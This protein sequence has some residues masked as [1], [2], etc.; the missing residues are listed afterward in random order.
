MPG[1]HVYT[2]KVA[3]NMVRLLKNKLVITQFMSR[4]NERD[5]NEGPPIGDSLRVKLPHRGTIRDGFDYVGQAIDRRY[6]T[7]DCTEKFGIDVDWDTIEAA[8]QMER[9][10]ED[11]NE[12]ILDPMAAKLAQECDSRAARFIY[13]NS[14]NVTGALGTTPTTLAAYSAVRTRLLETAGLVGA[15]RKGV[16]VTPEMMGTLIANGNNVLAL[17]NPTDTVAKAFKEGYIGMYGGMQYYESMSLYRHTTG[18]WTTVATGVTTS[19][20][21]QSGTSIAVACTTG[22]TFKAG[23]VITFASVYAVNKMTLRSTNRLKQFK[24]M[25]DTTGASSTATLTISP[26]IVGPGSP[27]QNVD[28]LPGN[29]VVL[30]LMPGT[31]MSNAAAKEGL[32]GI[33]LTDEAFALVG[34]DLPMP[35]KTS[36]EYIGKYTDPETGITAAIIRSFD[37]DRRAW[38]TR[39]DCWV[40]FGVMNAEDSSILVASLN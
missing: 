22:D 29:G 16:I 3:A 27:Y 37:F 2:D 35:K 6:T 12:N 19:S 15:K 25:A 21:S 26:G 14:P 34:V 32:F 36:E 9:T 8:T 20:G 17:F 30:T 33:G 5:F 7:I 24:I 10:D 28:A 23:D 39:M 4:K 1:T 38:K 18:V 40:G 31:S 11:I 13:L